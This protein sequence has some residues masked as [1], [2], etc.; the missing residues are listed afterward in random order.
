MLGSVRK[1][2]LCALLALS[3]CGPEPFD[4]SKEPDPR[5]KE[6]VLGVN[7]ALKITVWK[8]PELSGDARVRPDGTI[9]MP[10]VGD[11]VAAGRTPN[12]LKQEIGKKLAAYV[13]DETAAV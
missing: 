4:Y 2:L 7:D 12:E 8:N 13:K 3:A 10:L 11:I 1:V 6:F 5:K 9:T